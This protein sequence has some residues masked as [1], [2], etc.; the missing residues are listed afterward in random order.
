MF[1]YDGYVIPALMQIAVE[2]SGREL[3]FV[4]LAGAQD[5]KLIETAPRPRPNITDITY[6]KVALHMPNRN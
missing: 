1:N 6:D 5:G 4:T 2:R 3:V